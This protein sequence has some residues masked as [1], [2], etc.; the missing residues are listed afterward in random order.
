MELINFTCEWPNSQPDPPLVKVFAGWSLIT[1]WPRMSF[2]TIVNR[3]QVTLE[4][5]ISCKL[6]SNQTGNSRRLRPGRSL[7]GCNAS[8]VSRRSATSVSRRLDC[9]CD[10]GASV[11]AN[12]LTNGMRGSRAHKSV[13]VRSQVTII[14]WTIIRFLLTRMSVAPQ[15]RCKRKLAI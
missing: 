10:S 4:I 6:L 13:E 8:Q 3:S 1:R 2:G 14:N 12:K 11:Y 5:F 15:H 9:G 7:F